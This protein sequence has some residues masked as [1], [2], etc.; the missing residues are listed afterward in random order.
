MF[1]RVSGVILLFLVIILPCPGQSTA[2][3]EE[4]PAPVPRGFGDLTL[5]QDMDR[6]KDVLLDDPNFNFR[7]DPDVSMLMRP[8]ES[9]IECKGFSFIDRAYFQFYEKSLYTITLDMREEMIGHYTLYTTFTEK[10]GEP[11]RLSPTESVWES[12]ETLFILE[13]PLTVKYIDREIFETLKRQGRM[14][15]SARDLSRERF[16]ELF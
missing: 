1:L 9:L 8:N 6:V 12:A 3:G 16:L 11:D 13:R 15:E 7:G 14:E 4:G 2:S 10:Y 5:G